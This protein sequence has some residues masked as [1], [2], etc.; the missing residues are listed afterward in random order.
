MLDQ[1]LHPDDVAAA[2]LFLAQLP[3]RAMVPELQLVPARLW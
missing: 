2:V 3:P 1:S